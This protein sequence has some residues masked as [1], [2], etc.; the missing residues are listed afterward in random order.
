ME[1]VADG[2]LAVAVICMCFDE[3]GRRIVPPIISNI[4][5]SASEFTN[6]PIPVVTPFSSLTCRLS[7]QT[8]SLDLESFASIRRHFGG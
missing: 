5:A 2:R 1:T 4:I 8:I 3:D 6:N 7:S